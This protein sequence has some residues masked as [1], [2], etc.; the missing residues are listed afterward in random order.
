MSRE[1]K[2][3]GRDWLAREALARD[4]CLGGR[5][6]KLIAINLLHAFGPTCWTR[7]SILKTA[8]SGKFSSD[9]AIGEYGERIWRRV[10]S[11]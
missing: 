2:L 10:P 9:R 4:D 6:V 1:R 7:M 5:A 8:R 3:D 11:G